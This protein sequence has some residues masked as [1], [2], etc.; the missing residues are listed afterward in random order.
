MS[1][2]TH[3]TVGELRRAIAPCSDDSLVFC[4]S[5]RYSPEY[6]ADQVKIEWREGDKYDVQIE[7]EP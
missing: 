3:L 1:G 2:R 6:A 5:D 7:Y 4:R